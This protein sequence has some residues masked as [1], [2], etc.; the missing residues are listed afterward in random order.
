VTN[1]SR[2]PAFVNKESGTSEGA[3]AALEHAGSFDI[4]EVDPARLEN[5]I[6]DAVRKGEKRI[7]IS[8]GDGSIRTAVECVASTEVELA[9]LPSGTLNHF[10]KDHHLPLD[11]DEAARVAATAS[12]SPTDVGSVGDH[13][14]HGT[15]SIGAY[16]VF[17]RMRDRLEPH[18]GYR[19]STFLAGIWTFFT[20]PTI[21]VEIEIEGK[22][23]TYR[24]PMLFVAVGERELKVPTLG[25]RVPG[26]QRGLHVMAVRGRRRA[27]IFALT[28]DAFARGVDATSRAPDFDSYIVD[29]CT[30]KM[31]RGQTRISFDGEAM[32]VSTPLEYSL[33]RDA[34]LLVGEGTGATNK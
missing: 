30:V 7:L 20:M 15:S 24:T 26:G 8:G 10:A 4:H 14:F 29:K 5:E 1:A 25:G 32:T 19:I 22:R 9:V 11:M 17:M 18:F 6:S 16:V 28:I 13:R 21:A 27:R 33:D 31:R 34:L 2:I 23:T 3:R 12:A